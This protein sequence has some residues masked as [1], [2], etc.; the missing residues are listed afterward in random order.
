MANSSREAEPLFPEKEESKQRWLRLLDMA[1]SSREA[2]PLFPEKEE[3]KQR[4]LR[5]AGGKILRGVLLLLMWSAFLF[6]VAVLVLLPTNVLEP[7]LFKLISS[8]LGFPGAI[9]LFLGCPLLL[10]AILGCIYLELTP[11]ASSNEIYVRPPRISLW[12]YPVIVD[13]PMGVVSAA[14][15]FWVV[16]FVA[17]LIWAMGNY[18]VK[19]LHFFEPSSTEDKTL[20]LK[21]LHII[22]FRFG[23]VGIIYLNILFLPVARGSVLLRLID[24]PFEHAAKYHVWLGH[25]TMAVFTS[26]GVCYLVLWTFQGRLI[27]EVVTWQRVG[28]ANLPGVIALLSGLSMWVTSLGFVRQGYF[29]LFFYTHQLYVVFFVFMALHVGDFV[30]CMAIAGIFL[31]LLD[32]FM[33]FCQSRRSV[34]LLSAK[35]LP[36]GTFELVLAKPLSLKFSALSFIFLHVRGLSWLEW[37]PFSVSCSPLDA[38]DQIAFLVKPLGSW[39][40]KL[41]GA[42]ANAVDA[43]SIDKKIPCPFQGHIGVEGPYGHESDY[44]LKYEVLILVAGGIGVSPFIAILRDLLQRCSFNQNLPREVTL[45]WAVKKAK[46]L[47]IVELVSPGTIC[48]EYERK[49]ILNVH[50]YVTQEFEHAPDVENSADDKCKVMYDKTACIKPMSPLVGTYSNFWT[51]IYTLT[52]ILGFL[53]LEGLIQMYYLEPIDRN[54]YR[55]VAWWVRDV[56]LLIGMIFAITFLGGCTL[57]VWNCWEDYKGRLKGMSFKEPETDDCLFENSARSKVYATQQ[58]R[59]RLVQPANTCY[60][61]RPDFKELFKHFSKQLAGSNVGVLV[62][63]P[64]SLQT[65]VAA[66]CRF[67]NSVAFKSTVAFHYHSVSFDL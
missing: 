52:S 31:F 19:D 28:I 39:T 60:G 27:Q 37:H 41:K 33:R 65:S 4:W 46:E 6:W 53:V 64:S 24:I 15:L 38:K 10:I 58:I 47:K 17:Y 16:V 25:F 50:V 1:N 26:H 63:G 51:G 42:V 14:E 9:M 18:I 20:F 45:I 2:E 48:P 44:F 8:P 40:E 34:G 32:R 67:H 13:G 12:T 29:E 30:F 3:S 55:I 43:D 49:L 56:F 54:T 5:F 66:E 36:C 35:S 61:K 7:V 62:C 59:Q 23:S 11:Q 22:G 21:L 57:L